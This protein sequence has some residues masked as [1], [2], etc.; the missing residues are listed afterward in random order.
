MSTF[1]PEKNGYDEYFLCGWKLR[2]D[3]HADGIVPH[4]FVGGQGE[5]VQIHHIDVSAVGSDEEPFGIE[6]ERKETS[7][8]SW[9]KKRISDVIISLAL[10]F[11]IGQ[12]MSLINS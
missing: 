3:V 10:Q 12:R 11:L 4:D 1:A 8:D 6:G 7:A 9:E 5:G 2:Q